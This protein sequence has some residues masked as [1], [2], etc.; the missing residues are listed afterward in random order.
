MKNLLKE[1]LIGHTVGAGVAVGLKGLVYVK[2][3]GILTRLT[4]S[5]EIR[6]RAS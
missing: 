2:P 6:V 4:K 1:S 5:F 3:H